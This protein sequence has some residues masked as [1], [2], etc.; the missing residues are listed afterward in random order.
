[1]PTLIGRQGGVSLLRTGFLL[2][3]QPGAKLV[4]GDG[5]QRR[6]PH[7]VGLDMSLFR[8]E[9]RSLWLTQS[10]PSHRCIGLILSCI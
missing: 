7:T 8:G 6:S 10:G 4:S 5:T 1:M 3:R 2:L 9:Q